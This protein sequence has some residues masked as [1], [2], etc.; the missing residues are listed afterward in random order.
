MNETGTEVHERIAEIGI[1]SV[2]PGDSYHVRG[3]VGGLGYAGGLGSPFDDG[4]R[5]WND[6]DDSET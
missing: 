2:F 1:R 3:G 4:S 5:S 6:S